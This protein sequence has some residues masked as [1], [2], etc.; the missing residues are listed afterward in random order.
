M[1]AQITTNTTAV[2]Q[3]AQDIAKVFSDFG[4]HVDITSIGSI[5]FLIYFGAKLLRNK[6]PLGDGAIGNLLSSVV[7][8]EATPKP[9]QTQPQKT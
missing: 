9:T 4:V 7:N 8:L 5:L 1:I 2:Q 6:T 3:T